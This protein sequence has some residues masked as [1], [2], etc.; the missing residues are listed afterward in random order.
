V[1]LLVLAGIARSEPQIVSY[2]VGSSNSLPFLSPAEAAHMQD[3]REVLR[4]GVAISL[5]ATL[6][7]V[8][9]SVFSGL[10]RSSARAAFITSVVLTLLLIPFQYAF[11]YFHKLFFPQ[12]N[13]QF[14]I[15]SWLI[16]HFPL[17]F[18][19]VTAITW[20]GFT[21][22]ALGILWYIVPEK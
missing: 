5:A 9:R 6:I 8:L 18:F 7:V 3:V 12:G 13:W 17:K 16:T 20:I 22:L 21:L 1:F 2:L 4:I 11:E 10:Q 14:P 19:L 15:D